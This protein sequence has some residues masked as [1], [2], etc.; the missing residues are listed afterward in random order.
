MNEIII[1]RTFK[2][3]K[4]DWK[5]IQEVVKAFWNSKFY[6]ESCLL[7]KNI[8]VEVFYSKSTLEL[9]EKG[10]LVN[11]ETELYKDKKVYSTKE[12]LVKNLAKDYL[13]DLW[14]KSS[15][16][17][18]FKVEPEVDIWDIF[19]DVVEKKEISHRVPEAVQLE[20]LTKINDFFQDK[21][22]KSSYFILP[23]GYWKTAISLWA[24]INYIN[25]NIP[26]D[27]KVLFLTHLSP[28]MIQMIDSYRYMKMDNWDTTFYLWEET[29]NS[30]NWNIRIYAS[31]NTI[32]NWLKDVKL[33]KINLKPTSYQRTNKF[34]KITRKS[35]EWVNLVIWLVPSMVP[36]LKAHYFFDKNDFDLILVDEIHHVTNDSFISI[37]D[38]FNY[39]K[40]VWMTATPDRTD[41]DEDKIPEIFDNNLLIEK[42]LADWIKDWRLCSMKYMIKQ[43][44]W[45]EHEN[46]E[47]IQNINYKKLAELVLSNSPEIKSSKTIIF[48][49]S[50]K[51]AKDLSLNIPNSAF[52]W[53]EDPDTWKIILPS[54]KNQII[55]DYK[56]GLINTIITVDMLNEGFDIEDCNFIIFLR[57]TISRRIWIQQLGRW[58]RKSKGK[59]QLLV[60]DYVRFDNIFKDFSESFYDTNTQNIK[61]INFKLKTLNRLNDKKVCENNII[62]NLDVFNQYIEMY[63]LKKEEFKKERPTI[64][65]VL[66]KEEVLPF[67]IDEIFSILKSCKDI[68]LLYKS[69]LSIKYEDYKVWK[70]YLFDTNSMV[71]K[72]FYETLILFKDD[73][74]WLF[75]FIMNLE[76]NTNNQLIP[77]LWNSQKSYDLTKEQQEKLEKILEENKFIWK[78]YS[79]EEKTLPTGDTFI[80][81]KFSDKKTSYM[82]PLWKINK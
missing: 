75:K 55:K 50:L 13:F 53:A 61:Y 36:D 40:K 63:N 20:V 9:F 52:V 17:K 25:Q 38:Y 70:K 76:T 8:L 73:K 4:T 47:N 43:M 62:E 10:Y 72:N 3:D 24:G 80:Y 45:K 28:V 79:F 14:F 21:S 37:L 68:N 51:I 18:S 34:D 54:K 46:V 31:E 6:F 65:S 19:D 78:N 27:K 15:D 49:K 12:D 26:K 2:G 67:M 48:C 44:D 1:N 60:H 56:S 39:D 16:D 35:L 77:K 57:P 64:R 59:E 41:G 32:R 11:I 69:I 23:T 71:D 42:D 82:K 29:E 58:L 33:N 74:D 81:V 5:S 66:F 30:Y 22:K 7:K